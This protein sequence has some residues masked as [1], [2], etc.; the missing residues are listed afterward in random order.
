MTNQIDTRHLRELA[1]AATPGPW[2]AR[3]WS[4][5]F[6]DGIKFGYVEASGYELWDTSG[7]NTVAEA[8][9]AEHIAAANPQTMIA[10]LDELESAT[11]AGARITAENHLEEKRRLVEVARERQA[12]ID[13]ALVEMSKAPECNE[14]P[15]GDP[16]TCGW[17]SD[18]IRVR[19]ALTTPTENGEKQ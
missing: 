18:L 7:G 13:A 4:H 2:E 9:N 14:H 3:T 12:R 5:Q 10:L 1:E 15:D 16:I 19:R 6:D 8:R 11:K 17:K